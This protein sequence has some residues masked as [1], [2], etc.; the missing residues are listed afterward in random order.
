MTDEDAVQVMH[1]TIAVYSQRIHQR[2]HGH[3]VAWTVE[4]LEQEGRLAAV[5]ARRTFDPT[6]AAFGTYA[7]IRIWGAIWDAVRRML[8]GQ[9][10]TIPSTQVA[11][12]ALPVGIAWMPD[13]RPTGYEAVEARQTLR[14]LTRVPCVAS[15]VGILLRHDGWEEELAPLAREL[16]ITTGALAQRLRAARRQLQAAL[17]EAP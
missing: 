16:G 1:H 4:D 8:P 9:R 17:R 3:L 2:F 5:L 7:R 12:E 15:V 10:G 13:E 6:R 14:A 11:I